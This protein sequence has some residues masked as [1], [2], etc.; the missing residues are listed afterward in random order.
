MCAVEGD[1]ECSARAASTQDASRLSPHWMDAGH[2]EL[3][4]LV[5]GLYLTGPDLRR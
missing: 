3:D 4:F 2:V 1:R 5:M